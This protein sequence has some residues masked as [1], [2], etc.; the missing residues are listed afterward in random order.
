MAYQTVHAIHHQIS[1]LH[2]KP[3]FLPLYKETEVDWKFLRSRTL[4]LLCSAQLLEDTICYCSMVAKEM[5]NK[6]LIQSIVYSLHLSPPPS[7]PPL[8]VPSCSHHGFP[9]C[10]HLRLKQSC[11][12]KEQ[13]WKISG[14]I[15][16]LV[17]DFLGLSKTFYWQILF[18]QEFRFGIF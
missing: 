15:A 17:L 2:C 6:I 3:V 12:C 14:L 18:L 8:S 1:T 9:I 13:S 5:L 7:P 4:S 16:M 11:C 10:W